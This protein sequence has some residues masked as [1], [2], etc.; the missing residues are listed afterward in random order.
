MK[1][2]PRKSL[3]LLLFFAVA[4]FVIQSCG[5]GSQS[6]ST[7]PA[8]PP[9][10]SPGGTPPPPPPPPTGGGGGGSTPPSTVS[11]VCTWHGD[12]GRTGL[13]ASE[14]ALTPANVNTGQFGKIAS[15][16]VDDPVYAQPLY[17]ANVTISGAA[18][19][20]VY[21]ATEKA[22]IY[23]FEA[24]GKNATALWKKSLLAPGAIAAP[25]ADVGSSS[26]PD[27]GLTGT[28]AIDQASGT[29]YADVLSKEGGQFFHKLHAIDITSGAERAG[30]PV[31]IAGSV[32]G[33][34]TG[35]ANGTVAFNAFIQM[36]R[37]ALLLSNGVVYVA[38]GSYG[39]RNAYHGWVFAYNASSLQQVGIFNPD[40]NGAQGAIW[41]SA[42]GLAADAAGNLYA[43]TGNGTFDPGAANYGNSFLKLAAPTMTVLDYFTPFN[44]QDLNN[45]DID[46]GSEAP[47]LLPDQAGAHPH[48]VVGAGKQGTLYVV[49]RDNMGKFQASGD[50][51]IVQSI[52]NAVGV[53]NE[54]ANFSTPAFWNGA[55]YFVG[56]GDTLKKFAVSSAGTASMAGK[57]PDAFGYPGATPT[58]SASGTSNGIVWAIDRGSASLRAYDAANVGTE[59][60]TSN[61]NAGRDG[62]NAEA[63]RF[64]VPTVANGRVYVGTK[65]SLVIYGL[66]GK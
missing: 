38:F 65:S 24:D 60:W 21:V 9:S 64:T 51:Q 10:P 7:Q 53:D 62:L 20:V 26:V 58:V 5:G 17:V 23:A 6:S 2:G 54:R 11:C 25:Q 39:D 22:T 37:A 35:S 59:L 27:V 12:N 57:G 45:R 50:S 43:I 16:G 52:P 48:L 13:N 1:P 8:P 31:T 36:N 56:N 32:P 55:L 19:N 49:D 40:A 4:I 34:G 47:V 46:L 66:L 14:T 3:L 61:Q 28:P 41:Q 42:G 30:S 63:L 29:L 44:Q 18:H 33:T 15:F